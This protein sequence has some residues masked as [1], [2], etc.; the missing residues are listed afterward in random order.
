MSQSINRL[1]LFVLQE[2]HPHMTQED[3]DRIIAARKKKRLMRRIARAN[4][5]KIQRFMTMSRGRKRVPIRMLGGL[6]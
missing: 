3:V 1:S 6:L 4:R 5:L 2:K